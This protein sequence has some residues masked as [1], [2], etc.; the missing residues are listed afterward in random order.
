MLYFL[1]SVFISTIFITLSFFH[2]LIYFGR[3]KELSNLS[4]SLHNLAISSNILIILFY[5]YLNII[6]F[7]IYIL[8][9]SIT[10]N[11]IASTFA[12]FIF[13]IFDLKKILKPVIIVYIF[14]IIGSI[15]SSIIFLINNK[16]IIG[17]LPIIL[18]SI[19]AVYLFISAG[20][21]IIKTKQYNKNKFNKMIF[22]GII[23]MLISYFIF[24]I[25]K[26]I[27]I[28]ISVGY[29]IY[30]P[31]FIIIF[32]FEYAL[33]NQFNTLYKNLEIQV[34]ERT[35]TIKQMEEKRKIF[36]INFSHEIKTPLTLISNYI[37]RA[38]NNIKNQYGNRNNNESVIKDLDLVR[39]NISRI[40]RDIVNYLDAEKIERGHQV[41][42]HDQI[43]NFSKILKQKIKLFENGITNKNL[44]LSYKIIDDLFIKIDTFAI[45]R[46]INNLMDN[47]IKYTKENGSI[48][49][50]LK[51]NNK[52]IEFIVKDT[53]I[54]IDKKDIEFIFQ[55]FSQLSKEK[56]Q[57]QGM[58]LGLAIVK[59]ICDNINAKIKVDSKLNKGSKFIIIFDKYIPKNTDIIQDDY[60]FLK[61]S[62]VYPSVSESNISETEIYNEY[63]FVVFL[64][65]DNLEMV[66]FLQENLKKKYNFYYS[67]NGKV[68]L[69]KLQHIPKPDI[70]ISDIMMNE[71]DGYEFY[72]I[73]KNNNSFNNI[74]LLFLT[75]KSGIDEKIKGLSKGAIDFIIKP[76]ILD[77]LLAKIESILKM[78]KL[79]EKSI[80]ESMYKAS[81]KQYEKIN[82]VRINYN[83]VKE[84][85]KLTN[86][87]VEICKLIEE[88]LSNK[89]IGVRLKKAESTIKNYIQI[90]FEKFYVNKREK[91]IDLLLNFKEN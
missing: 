39:N 43:I 6:N 27:F 54:G 58:G 74:P 24:G 34:K 80:I 29:Y 57:L 69:E 86:K 14:V 3:K 65:E 62:P 70:I 1:Y 53:G 89:E 32:F 78:N 33:I 46:I 2:L 19:Y 9:M 66:A 40:Q 41:Y 23:T 20:I 90:I 25:L 72:E 60:S 63:N 31:I 12:F 8:F 73:L 30:T 28:D 17:T 71:M 67:L 84:V 49:I 61:E 51:N 75:A 91:L 16:I 83:K 64:V 52:K 42:Q 26:A 36:F 82:K 68:A 47:A 5:R 81:K 88:N 45:E 38:Y 35:N 85:Y 59:E 7:K 22:I 11:L 48:N 79:N 44:H 37:E 10:I 50:L 21:I 18:C 15:F 55:P 87:E 13:T 4:Y 56:N 76:F 77:E